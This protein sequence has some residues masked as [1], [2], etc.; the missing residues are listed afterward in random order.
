MKTHNS[1]LILVAI[2]LAALVENTSLAANSQ[3]S[4][5]RQ[6]VDLP[7]RLIW[8]GGKELPPTARPF[9]LYLALFPI[10]GFHAKDTIQHFETISIGH[11]TSVSLDLGHLTEKVVHKARPANETDEPGFEVEPRETRIVRLAPGL[12]FPAG[13]T[14]RIKGGIYDADTRNTLLLAY[15]DRPSHVTGT[16]TAYT[17][18]ESPPRV[19]IQVDAP[20]W[21]W[22]ELRKTGPATYIEDRVPSPHPVLLITP[23]DEA[24]YRRA[25]EGAN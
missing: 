19:D 6:I 1:A 3:P 16:D 13:Q 17:P 5:S 24:V 9:H 22:I 10:P 18:L 12:W 2:Q 23:P 25:Q 8:T 4:A 20:G 11:D 7:I 14:V 15:F 21:V